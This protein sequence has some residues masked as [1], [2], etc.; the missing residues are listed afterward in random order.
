MRLK[1]AKSFEAQIFTYLSVCVCE[2]ERFICNV[3][4]HHLDYSN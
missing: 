1:K 3:F 4:N 2:R